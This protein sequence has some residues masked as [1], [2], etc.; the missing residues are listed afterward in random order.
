[1][2]GCCPAVLTPVGVLGRVQVRGRGRL[3]GQLGHRHLVWHERVAAAEAHP[4]L[5]VGADLEAEERGAV[6]GGGGGLQWGHGD[7]WPYSPGVLL[8]PW[9]LGAP[10]P[11]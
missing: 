9:G 7:P 10:V 6:R 3:D 5:A 1:M 11:P 8:L 4:V 2:R